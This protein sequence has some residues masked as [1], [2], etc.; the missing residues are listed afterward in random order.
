[1]K[2]LDENWHSN[3]GVKLATK[4]AILIVDVNVHNSSSRRYIA[5]ALGVHHRKILVDLSRRT[6]INDSG[7]ALCSLFIKKKRTDRLP[8]LLK[9]AVIDWWTS[10]T[11]VSPNKN[12]VVWKRLEVV[13]YD[14][15]PMHFLMETQVWIL[16]HLFCFH[17]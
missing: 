14:E 9:E 5:K 15:K 16:K 1:M 6:I 7:L 10:E 12:N 3:S 11:C 8:N 17:L 13:V 4:H 2:A